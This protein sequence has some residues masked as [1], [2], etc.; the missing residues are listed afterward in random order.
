[1]VTCPD[2]VFSSRFSLLQYIEKWKEEMKRVH[3]VTRVN[4]QKAD[5]IQPTAFIPGYKLDPKGSHCKG[6]K[7]QKVQGESTYT[8]VASCVVMIRA[9]T[10][11]QHEQERLP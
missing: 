11:A 4:L 10:N 1:M 7:L 3:E 9:G 6:K 5:T 2:N 8:L